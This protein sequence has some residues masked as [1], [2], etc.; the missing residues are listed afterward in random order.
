MYLYRHFE[1]CWVLELLYISIVLSSFVGSLN[2]YIFISV[3]SS[4]VGS[5]N[6]YVFLSSFRVLL[7]P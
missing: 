4:L 3:L 2:C 1:F 6:W 7:G 5:L